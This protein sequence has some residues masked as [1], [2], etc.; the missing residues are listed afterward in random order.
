MVIGWMGNLQIQVFE[1]WLV[2]DT[3]SIRTRDR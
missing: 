2:G 3:W 1:L